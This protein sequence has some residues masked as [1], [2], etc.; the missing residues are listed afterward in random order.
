MNLNLIAVPIIHILK[1]QHLFEGI[2]AHIL[3]NDKHIKLNYA[4]ESFQESLE[5]LAAKGVVHI[6]IAKT[7]FYNMMGQLQS[8]MANNRFYDP[9]TTDELRAST[10]NTVY[11]LSKTYINRLGAT[12]EVLEMMK[13]A[14]QK[15]QKILDQ[16]PGIFAF[17]KRFKAN[18]SEEYLK[19][20]VTNLFLTMTLS[21][22]PWKSQL[23]VQKSMMA[24]L[25]CDITM[26][27]K[28]FDALYHYQTQGGELDDDVARH[29]ILAS[30][31]LNRKRDLI[32]SE[33]ITIIEQHHERPDGKGFPDGITAMRFNQLSA[34]FIV[35]QRFVDLLFKNEFDHN[36]HHDMINELKPVY[37]GG[38]FDKAMDALIIV[39]EEAQWGEVTS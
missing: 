31:I 20:S 35:C 1:H 26:N 27:S 3:V 2:E 11:E 39:V 10:C 34:V 29:P 22:F 33:T 28:S 15:M 32:P 7:D 30:E 24:S 23:I 21:K 17:V 8:R 16:S 5:K 18:C 14:N 12:A 6:Y 37:Q 19:I 9:L 36:R 25:L 38:H 4:D 13:D